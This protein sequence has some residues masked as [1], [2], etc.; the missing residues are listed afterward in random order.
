MMIQWEV[1]TVFEILRT[2]ADK[3]FA[4]CTE[5]IPTKKNT[6]HLNFTNDSFEMLGGTPGLCVTI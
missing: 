5:I 4:A 6:A 2:K 1:L 3:G